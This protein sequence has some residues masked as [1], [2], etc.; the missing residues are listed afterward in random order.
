MKFI[1][2]KM[3][4]LAIV[5]SAV[6]SLAD[7]LEPPSIQNCT[8]CHGSS[9]QGYATAP[10]LAG[11]RPQYTEKQL[12][13]FREHA[14]N[15]PSSKHMWGPAANLSH[16]MARD[17]AIY[18]AALPPKAANDG[19][20][21]LVAAG[22]TLYESGNPAFNIV[23]CVVCHGSKA[24]GIRQIP[25][26]GGLSYYY[27]KRRL[28]EWGEGYHVSAE[29][30]MPQI[31]ANLPPN[32]IEALASYLSFDA[33]IASGAPTK[34][35]VSMQPASQSAQTGTA[36]FSKRNLEAKIEYCNSCHGLSGQGYRGFF[37]MPRLAGQQA[38]Y[39]EKQLL[40]FR[41]HAR[42]SPS[43]K[44]MWGPAANLSHAMAR[45]LAIY[46]AALPPKAANDG[47]RKLVAAGRTLYESGKPASNIVSCAVCHG[48]KAEG[49]R[50]I[51]RLGGLSYYYLKRRLEEWSKG[52]HASAEAP[53]PQIAASLPRNA[54][55][56]L[57]SYLS[58]VR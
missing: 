13:A 52:H 29:A 19:E 14:R 10:R 27:L 6:P 35:T 42:N 32:V 55:D 25:R 30:P 21:K 44:H 38:E 18:F 28:E 47:E 15:S 12:L 45:D 8:W 53:M 16:A 5:A 34:K 31:A 58:F 51:P 39:A 43:S 48:P 7:N 22:R 1:R 4:V 9:A 2:S 37:P 33:V 40:A 17:L 26:L 56:A 41:E 57:A 11:Q 46:F 36:A 3:A 49:T 24:E 23:S 20:R 50:Q 54:I